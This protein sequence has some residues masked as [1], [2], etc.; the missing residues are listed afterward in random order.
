MDLSCLSAIRIFGPKQYFLKR[1]KETEDLDTVSVI[2]IRIQST[3]WVKVLRLPYEDDGNSLN[4]EGVGGSFLLYCRS[5]G[6]ISPSSLSFGQEKKCVHLTPLL[7]PCNCLHKREKKENSTLRRHLFDHF[8]GSIRPP[9][10][11]GTSSF[12]LPLLNDFCGP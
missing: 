9:S 10:T 4:S 7:F 12:S 8:Y 5:S 1:F 2:E 3:V 6:G 11:L